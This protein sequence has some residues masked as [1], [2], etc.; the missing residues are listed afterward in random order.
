M[1]ATATAA[2]A[3]RT[4]VLRDGGFR[5]LFVGSAMS[6]IGSRVTV[7]ALPLVAI[8]LLNASAVE[9]GALTAAGTVAFLLIG[10]PAGAWID[11]MRKQRVLVAADL[12]RAAVIL[13]IPVAGWLGVLTV[14]QLYVVAFLHGML[15]VFFDVAYQ[16]YVPYLV[17]RDRLVAGNARLQT[18]ESGATV[19]A[20]AIAGFVIQTVGSASAMLADTLSFLWSAFAIRS[21]RDPEPPR[22]RATRRLRQEVVE[23]LR[24]V[25]ADRSLRAI[26]ACTGRTTCSIARRP[27]C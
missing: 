16:S 3:A 19:I 11:R 23:G 6:L 7:V 20:P 15:T 10:L 24:F 2:D 13:S 5:R 8:T 9:V 1:T 27:R 22:P 21:I 14:G 18:V 26:A 25:F 4:N 12:G 17:G